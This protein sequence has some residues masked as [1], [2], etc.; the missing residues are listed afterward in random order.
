MHQTHSIQRALRHIETSLK[1]PLALATL[2][3]SAGMSLWHFQRTFSAMVGEPAGSYLRRRRLTEAARILRDSHRTI[4]EVAIEYCFESHAAFTRAFKSEMAVTP[5]AWRTGR[6]SIPPKRFCRPIVLSLETIRKRYQDMK[7]VPDIVTLPP[8]RFVGL[9]TKFV[10]ATSEHSDNLQ[11]IPRLWDEFTRRS[12]V[13]HPL[14]SGVFFG[15]ADCPESR[16]LKPSRPDEVLYLAGV[17]TS[18]D[19]PIPDGMVAWTST[20][21]TYAKFLH[22]GPIGGIGRTMGFIY[23]QWLPEGD[24]QRAEGPDMERYDGRFDPASDASVL[25]I[26]VPVDPVGKG[27]ANDPLRDAASTSF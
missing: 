14:E 9:Q 22:R 17:E 1:E 20:G 8:R 21:G 27:A 5:S 4:L 7:L 10:S 23:G 3:R 11:I 15:L 13:L 6:A 25:E 2:A 16:G 18:V 19:A 26:F 12:H 24:Y